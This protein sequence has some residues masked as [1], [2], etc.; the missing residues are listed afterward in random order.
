MNE[1][2]KCK[3]TADLVFVVQDKILEISIP[4]CNLCYDELKPRL[5][6]IQRKI[7][8]LELYQQ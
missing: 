7:K 3:E 6:E 2:F 5:V 1:C 4:T 8:R